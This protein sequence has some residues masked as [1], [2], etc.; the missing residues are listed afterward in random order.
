M[1]KG[2]DTSRSLNR[3]PPSRDLVEAASR[4]RAHGG[5]VLADKRTGEMHIVSPAGSKWG[6]Y[7]Q[8]VNHLRGGD[9]RRVNGDDDIVDITDTFDGDR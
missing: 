7:D 4:A 1:P 2:L 8:T 3:R 5:R 6:S 9:L